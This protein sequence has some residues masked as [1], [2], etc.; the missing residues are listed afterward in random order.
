MLVA[1][2]RKLI[3]QLLDL[4]LVL[5][6]QEINIIFKVNETDRRTGAYIKA[7]ILVEHEFSYRSILSN[8]ISSFVTMSPTNNNISILWFDIPI[9]IGQN[10]E[11]LFHILKG[12]DVMITIMYSDDIL[13]NP[14]I[15]PI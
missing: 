3:D 5:P 9:D 7:V 2:I 10:K 15:N 1:D 12:Q 4:N 8:S 6:N 11:V 13:S 14:I